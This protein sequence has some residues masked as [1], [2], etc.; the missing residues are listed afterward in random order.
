MESKN[1]ATAEAAIK[2]LKD[3]YNRKNQSSLQIFCFFVGI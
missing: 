2:D 1:Y 3:G